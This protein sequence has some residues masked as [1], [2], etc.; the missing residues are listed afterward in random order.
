[1]RSQIKKAARF[2]VA[3]LFRVR[4]LPNTRHAKH[5]KDPRSTA[6]AQTKGDSVVR[7]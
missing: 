5:E 3:P 1:V 4:G 7:S 2:A 6:I